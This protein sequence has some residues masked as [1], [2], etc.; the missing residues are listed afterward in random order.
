ML[1]IGK[2]YDILI[3]EVAHDKE[4]LV[5]HNKAYE[6]IL[7]PMASG[8]Y[9]CRPPTTLPSPPTPPTSHARGSM[10]YLL[11]FY[12]RYCHAKGMMS[13]V[14]FAFSRFESCVFPHFLF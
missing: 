11:Y 4:H 2:I 10:M 14:N 12:G 13:L 8:N 7:V 3:T 1:Q 9:F 6:Q 5:G